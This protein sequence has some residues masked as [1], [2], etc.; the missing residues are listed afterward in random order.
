MTTI[1]RAE[2]TFKADATK[3]KFFNN[4]TA[5]LRHANKMLE[6]DFAG[7]GYNPNFDAGVD[8]FASYLEDFTS[9]RWNDFSTDQIDTIKEIFSL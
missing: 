3:T 6:T 1:N 9:S 4:Q 7:T 2:V 8:G 5:D